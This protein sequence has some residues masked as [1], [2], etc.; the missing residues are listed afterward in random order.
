[1]NGINI[2]T[3]NSKLTAKIATTREVIKM[4]LIS[5]IRIKERPAKEASFHKEKNRRQ[6]DYG[7]QLYKT[8]E[9]GKSNQ[10]GFQDPLNLDI[11]ST[12]LR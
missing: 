12:R 11:L 10:N 9:F 2:N 8:L 4:N 6:E 1:M 3:N 5:S 7:Y